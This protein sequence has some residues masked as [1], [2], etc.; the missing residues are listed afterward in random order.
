MRNSAYCCVGKV[1]VV[2]VLAAR[3]SLPGRAELN[4]L[5]RPTLP[6]CAPGPLPV[7]LVRATHAQLALHGCARSVH[8]IQHQPTCMTL[9][10]VCTRRHLETETGVPYAFPDSQSTVL[11]LHSCGNFAGNVI[12]NSKV[13]SHRYEWHL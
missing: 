10:C 7:A 13:A 11:C 5:G 12:T 9:S 3:L 8:T 6:L 1:V 2:V 4:K